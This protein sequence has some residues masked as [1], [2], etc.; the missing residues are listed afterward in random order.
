LYADAANSVSDVLYSLFM[1][2]GIWMAMRPPDIVTSHKD[3]VDSS[4]WWD[5]GYHFRWHLP[6]SRLRKPHLID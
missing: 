6:V 5:W 4:R 3:T 2:L 1:V